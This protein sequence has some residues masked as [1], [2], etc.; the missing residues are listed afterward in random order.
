MDCNCRQPLSSRRSDACQAYNV[1]SA[2]STYPAQC[3]LSLLVQVLVF[4][5]FLRWWENYRDSERHLKAVFVTA[6]KTLKEQVTRLL[7]E[8]AGQGKQGVAKHCNCCRVTCMLLK[9]RP[10]FHLCWHAESNWIAC[11]AWLVLLLYA[12]R[13]HPPSDACKLQLSSALP[14]QQLSKLLAL[15]PGA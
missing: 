7:F 4:R 1:C 2:G 3:F 8:S 6:S 15:T 13:S 5:M 9:F 10:C 11:C 12:L 14:M